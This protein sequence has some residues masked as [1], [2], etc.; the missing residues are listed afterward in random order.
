[1]AEPDCLWSAAEAG[2]WA[3]PL[4]LDFQFQG[5]ELKNIIFKH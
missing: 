1:M 5:L 4:R 3:F 2:P